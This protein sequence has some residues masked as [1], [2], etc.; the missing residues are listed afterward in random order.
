MGSE[1]CIRDRFDCGA[2]QKCLLLDKDPIYRD[3]ANQLHFN[4]IV[5][6]MKSIRILQGVGIAAPYVAGN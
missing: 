4:S 3:F 5:A 6:T 1:M 2:N